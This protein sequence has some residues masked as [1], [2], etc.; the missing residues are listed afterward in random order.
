MALVTIA[1]CLI[2]L[3]RLGQSL[4]LKSGA[5]EELVISVADSVPVGE[6][7]KILANVEDTL[8]LAS[9]HLFTALDGR[10]YLR[11]ATVVLPASWPDSCA[12]KPVSS[13]TGDFSDVT[14]LPNDLTRGTIWTQQ[15]A[16]CG[17]PGDQIYLAYETLLKKD[18]TLARLFVKQF[19]MYRYGVFDEQGY[20]NDP[21]Y[22]TCYYDDENRKNR[23][24]G[25]SDLP[26]KDNG[27]CSSAEKNYNKSRM[28]DE[29]ARSSLMFAAEVPS[30]SMFCDE[31]THD[32]YA[33]TKHNLICNRRST[34]DIISNHP[35][36]SVNTITPNQY[37]NEITNTTTRVT[38]RKQNTTRYILVIENTKDMQ[39]RESW[40][41][42]R[43]AIR[44]WSLFDLPQNSEVGVILAE[45][46]GAKKLVN[47]LSLKKNTN[48]G[49]IS[50]NLPYNTGD[51]SQPACLHCAL[52]DAITMLVDYSK[53]RSGARNVIVLIAPGMNMNPQLENLTNEARKSKIRIATINFPEV[54]RSHPLDLL[55]TQT[56][57]VA[58]TVMEQKF[59]VDMSMLSSY[60][61]L[62]NVLYNV[63]ERFYSGNPSELPMEIHRRKLTDDGRTSI[64]G[65]F[66]L[67]ENMGEPAR[68]MLYTHNA[69]QPLIRG[70]S[71]IS[72]SHQ[73]YT[74]RSEDMVVAKIL[75]LRVNISEPGTWTYTIERDAGNPQPHYVQ[76]MATPRSRTVPVVRTKFWV[77]TNQ[78]GGPLILLTEVK[79]GN[80]PILGAKVLVTF[81]RS[82]V[83]G[84][85]AYS[86][87]LELLDTGSGDPDITKGDGIYS[88]YFSAAAG[89][90][91][92]YTF[93]VIVTDNGNTAY[94]WQTNINAPDEKPCCGSAVPTYSVQPLS[95][96]QRF[97]PPITIVFTSDDMVRAS[98]VAVG[99]IGDLKVQVKPEDMKALLTWTSPDLGGTRAARYQIKYSSTL[100]DIVD[101]YEVLAQAWEYDT[102]HVLS[103]GTE[104]TFTLDMTKAKHLLDKPLYFAIRSYPQ[105]YSDSLASSLSNWVRVLVPS[106]PPP[107]TVPP[108][109]IPNDQTA[110]PNQMNPSIDTVGPANN[111]GSFG[112]EVVL[113]IVIGVVILAIILSLYCYFCVI[114]RRNRSSHKKSHH[115]T[116]LQTDKLSSAV[117]IVP[118]SP[119][120]SSQNSQGYINHSDLPDHHTIGVPINSFAFDDEPKKRYS[121]V[122][123]QEQQLIEELKQQQMQQRELNTQNNTYTGL[124]VISSN[125]LQRNGHT[126]SPYN[127]W[128]ASQLLHEHERRHSP[129][130]NM[131]PED[132][133]LAHHQSELDHM[134]LNGQN[135]DHISMNGHQI[136]TQ[137]PDHYGQTHAPPVPPLPAYNSNGYPVNYNIYGVHQPPP[138][139]NH[140]IYQTMQRNESMAPY[141]NNSLQGSLNS[142]NS[143]EKKRRN[144]T[145]V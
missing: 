47:I 141:S 65:S 108:T 85:I 11:S 76:V 115:S 57:G 101:N 62:T 75:S 19:A 44:K 18:D 120:H 52:K 84:S 145:M 24:T 9:Q 123:Q 35:D 83:N 99:R 87:S 3:G 36:F 81:T 33:P 77:R 130:D 98:Q 124:S 86:D 121:L 119:L 49:D 4:E 22:P 70:L 110:W 144:V 66:V 91:G 88:R 8:A 67:D 28:V 14:I 41:H 43:N 16:G 54:V 131:I 42:L 96:F 106:P 133:L 64:T 61:Q 2:S 32:Q 48:A 100:N 93:D 34:F 45:N 97:L 94:T 25:C 63:I 56:D 79:Q 136:V 13:G 12:P 39:V 7:Q 117:T 10:A 140:P 15:S 69:E 82:E 72:P 38:Y 89:G 134:S 26:I 5:Y 31:G 53:Y 129:M 90:P 135:V 137:I 55:A 30:V 102:P 21:V 73:E 116:G 40:S 58:Y 105:M 114:K 50:S 103:I 127:S 23:V 51:S 29:K 104:T 122:H 128:S 6:C 125:S 109:Y 71:L 37:T 95:P 118:S 78:P 139:Q 107:P 20:E 17:Q 126:L 138:Q 1:I 112:L 80:W 59:N 111:N 27:I 143:G 46:N 60:F 68:F 132:Q 113:P 92:T 142:V 74:G